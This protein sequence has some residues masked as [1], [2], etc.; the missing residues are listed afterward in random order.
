LGHDI[1]KEKIKM[2][3]EYKQNQQQ[4]EMERDSSFTEKTNERT[5]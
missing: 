5:T 2:E 1:D 4:A 3:N